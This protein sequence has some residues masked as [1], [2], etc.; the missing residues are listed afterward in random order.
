MA[1]APGASFCLGSLL[2]AWR[3]RWARPCLRPPMQAQLETQSRASCLEPGCVAAA[4]A[5][6][7]NSQR[8]LYH[9]LIAGHS[10]AWHHFNNSGWQSGRCECAADPSHPGSPECQLDNFSLMNC[11]TQRQNGG[12]KLLAPFE[13]AK[14]K[15]QQAADAVAT[16]TAAGG[17]G[18]A[19]LSALQVRQ[20][21]GGC[22]QRRAQR[23][24]GV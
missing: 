11:Y 14:I 4:A 22:G 17:S 24:G 20:K 12:A 9:L 19:I 15:L 6:S 2:P 1:A 5:R 7:S 3:R 18:A 13:S 10:S 23:S 16:A 8:H 21:W